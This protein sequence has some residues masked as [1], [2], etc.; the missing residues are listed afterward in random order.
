MKFKTWLN[1]NKLWGFKDIFGFEKEFFPVV[2]KSKD[3]PIKGYDAGKTV[4]EL[5][6][7]PLG[8]KMPEVRFSNE[9]HWGRGPGALRVMIES[10]LDLVI[11]KLALGLDGKP[12]WITKKVYQINQSGYGGHEG[13][14]A[15]EVMNVLQ[16]VDKMPPD[17][18]VGDWD[19]LERLVSTMAST[20]R[21]VA[22][23]V[24]IFEGVR[25]SDKDHYIIR[26]A[27]RGQGVQAPG[28]ARVEENQ[29][30]V[31]YCRETGLVRI[32]NYNVESSL[33]EH[34]W[35]LTPSDANWY[36]APTQPTS[37]IVQ[38]IANNLSWY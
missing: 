28:Q 11:D 5:A 7:H 20:L 6:R 17:S 3:L 18:P 9:V 24:F 19:G 38:T 1:E 26:M 23:D 10:K 37:E 21:R 8:L 31:S 35:A 13:A 25:Q 33:G 15:E 32:S 4:C 14:V 30:S 12:C 29:T 36:Y 16:E 34:K 27:V 22:T 2:S